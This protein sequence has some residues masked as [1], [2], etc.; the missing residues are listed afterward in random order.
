MSNPAQAARLAAAANGFT[1]TIAKHRHGITFGKL[2]TK[3][4]CFESQVGQIYHYGPNL[5]E[6]DSAW[7][8]D[9]DQNYL[10]MVKC[11]FNLRARK[12]FNGGDLVTWSDPASGKYVKFQ[13]QNLQ[14]IGN[15]DSNSVISTAQAISTPVIEEEDKL[16]WANAFGSGRHFRYTASTTSLIKHLI[17]DQGSLPACPTY[18]TNPWLE[19]TFSLTP[20][21]DVTIY[22]DGVAWDN[23]TSKTTANRIEF[24]L[25]TGK[26]V[27]SLA[28][29]RAFDSSGDPETGECAGQI[30]I[31]VNKKIKYCGVRFPKA[32]IDTAQFPVMLDPAV[33]YQVG[34]GADDARNYGSTHPGDGGYA[35][36]Y[37]SINL[38]ASTSNYYI[39][40]IRFQ[41]VAV[42]AG[43]TVD[44]AYAS[45]KLLSAAGDAP[46]LSVA[47]EDADDASTF[48]SGTHEPYDAYLAR[49]TAIISWSP[50]ETTVDHW[51]GGAGETDEIDLKTLVQEVIDRPGWAS[52]ND[53][54]FVFWYA[55]TSLPAANTIRIFR[56]YEMEGNVSGP[57]L[58][59]EYTEAAAGNPH[60][61]YAQQ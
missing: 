8:A 58:H 26:V 33:D 29:P 9:S 11:D 23:S 54:V 25:S 4:R 19:L 34:A 5:E 3:Q 35:D 1:E 46:S 37:T 2:G 20:S 61:A 52:G 50:T 59:I 28:A 55:P 48:S 31:Y 38:G 43:A 30:R 27:W 17:L 14:W 42:P 13:P 18:I 10:K 57:K 39:A 53:L 32:W 7:E 22:I 12:L 40:G 41:T 6:A 47:C 16:Y 45:F 24:R 44:H 36:M 21:A 56:S 49:T 51:F 15:Y 60:Y